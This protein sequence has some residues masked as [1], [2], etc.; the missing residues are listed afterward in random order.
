MS[1]SEIQKK[2]GKLAEIDIIVAL[3]KW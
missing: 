1:S 3:E 2:Q